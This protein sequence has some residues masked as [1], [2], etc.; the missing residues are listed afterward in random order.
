MC[1][2]FNLFAKV[3]CLWEEGGNAKFAHTTTHITQIQNARA[4]YTR[5]THTE[6]V[7][8]DSIWLKIGFSLKRFILCVRVRGKVDYHAGTILTSRVKNFHGPARDFW[9]LF[10]NTAALAP[11]LVAVFKNDRRA[12]LKI[13]YMSFS[14]GLSTV[15]IGSFP[16]GIIP[17]DWLGGG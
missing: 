17:G 15:P 4:H 1:A 6:E 13:S 8:S 14:V 5:A 10:L 2:L 16:T 11:G 12:K 7:K 3:L 9:G